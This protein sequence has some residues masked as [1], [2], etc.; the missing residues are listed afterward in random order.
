MSQ[1][2]FSDLATMRDGVFSTRFSHTHQSSLTSAVRQSSSSFGLMGE[3]S[4]TAGQGLQ[5][6]VVQGGRMNASF[7]SG[8]RNSTGG[9]PGDRSFSLRMGPP[10][11]DDNNPSAQLPLSPL[12]NGPSS[13]GGAGG[14]AADTSKHSARGDNGQQQQHQPDQ[15]QVSFSD[16]AGMSRDASPFYRTAQQQQQQVLQLLHCNSEENLVQQSGISGNWTGVTRGGYAS[17]APAIKR[18]FDSAHPPGT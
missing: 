11:E 3:E 18:S 1:H 17:P 16:T 10:S 8:G 9:G 14:A 13:K 2:E 5:D 4:F 15:R 6:G 12:P 7:S